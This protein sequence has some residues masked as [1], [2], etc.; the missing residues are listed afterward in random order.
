VDVIRHHE[1]F[2]SVAQTFMTAVR[3]GSGNLKLIA[4]SATSEGP[5]ER[6]GDLSVGPGSHPSLIHVGAGRHA[7]AYR[8]GGGDLR[9]QC[10]RWGVQG[11]P[12]N[13]TYAFELQEGA[14]AGS[15][16]LVSAAKLPDDRCVTA[17]R[18]SNG[19]LKMILWKLELE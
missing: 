5:I 7:V 3:G 2:S 8:D 17:V 6:L 16:S 4:W 13:P 1:S 19:D 14:G 12:S 10:F 9:V 15:S 11:T 18:A